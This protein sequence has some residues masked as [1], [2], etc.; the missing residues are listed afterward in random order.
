MLR[1]AQAG[2]R[3]RRA[4]LFCQLRRGHAFIAHLSRESKSAEART[5]AA[6]ARSS[7]DCGY[8]R[9]EPFQSRLA[10][11]APLLPAPCGPRQPS[12]SSFDSWKSRPRRSPAAP[13]AASASSARISN[14]I[15]IRSDF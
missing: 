2:R 13:V 12:A 10:P 3:C 8:G 11:P 6:S 15:L 4:P 7:G 14:L 1:T 9:G 5:I